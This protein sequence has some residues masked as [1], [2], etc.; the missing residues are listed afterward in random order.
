MGPEATENFKKLL[1]GTFKRTGNN[2]FC[3][4]GR[5]SINIA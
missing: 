1:K 2:R 3:Y 5:M 4:P